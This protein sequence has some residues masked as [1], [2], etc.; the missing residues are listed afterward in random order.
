MGP[1]PVTGANMGESRAA[2][3]SEPREQ[4]EDIGDVDRAVSGEILRRRLA[5]HSLL[6]ERRQQ[7]QNIADC[8]CVPLALL[9]AHSGLGPRSRRRHRQREFARE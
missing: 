5:A 7:L 3:L 4:V 9:V 2:L 1:D 8:D 6:S